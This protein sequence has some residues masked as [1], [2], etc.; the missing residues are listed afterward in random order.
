MFVF[1]QFLMGNTEIVGT[2]NQVHARVQRVQARSGVPT[3]AGQA[4][5]SFAEG[6]IQ[7]FDKR[8]IEH[9]SPT[10]K[11]E[12]LLYPVTNRLQTSGDLL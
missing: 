1:T 12:Q 8:R 3:F 11:L 9:L 10:G 6:G 4:C 2:A 5:Q 7:A